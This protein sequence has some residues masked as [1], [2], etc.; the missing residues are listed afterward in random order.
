MPEPEN[1]SNACDVLDNALKLLASRSTKTKKR[2][3]KLRRFAV[4]A[5]ARS[6]SGSMALQA[7]NSEWLRAWKHSI[8]AANYYYASRIPDK[9]AAGLKLL[10]SKMESMGL[11]VH[12]KQCAKLIVD[13]Q[14]ARGANSERT[15]D[16]GHV[17]YE[18]VRRKGAMLRGLL[19]IIEVMRLSTSSKLGQLSDDGKLMMLALDFSGRAVNDPHWLTAEE[20]K[21][22][23][24]SLDPSLKTMKMIRKKIHKAHSVA[25]MAFWMGKAKIDT[26][27]KRK[28]LN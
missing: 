4:L 18:L 16:P 10:K 21:E 19:N 22:E 20:D 13:S 11:T 5:I 15:A 6:N 7:R 9:S 27:R 1:N 23:K 17:A 28:S 25:G 24:F 14:D 2:G 26:F 12:S 3:L 8:T